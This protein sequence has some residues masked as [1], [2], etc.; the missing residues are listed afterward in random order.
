M[1]IA[2]AQ[3]FIQRAV[4]D[5]PLIQILN[6]A[7]DLDEFNQMLA[8]ID[9]EF[10]SEEFEAAFCNVLGWCQTQQQ[11]DAVNEIKQWYNFLMQTISEN[12]KEVM[13]MGCTPEQ[14]AACGQKKTPQGCTP[15][16]AEDCTCQEEKKETE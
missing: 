11:A 8:E 14:C 1:T 4:N 16:E 7:L 6:T 9:L 5:Y 12:R 2:A 15:Q 10:D 3:S 13:P